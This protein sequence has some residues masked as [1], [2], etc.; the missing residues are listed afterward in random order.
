MYHKKPIPEPISAPQ[1]TMSS[2]AIW[3]WGINKYSAINWLPIAYAIKPKPPPIKIVGK[4]ARPSRPSVR[5]TAFEE[6]TITKDPNKINESM[7]ISKIQSLLKRRI[8]DISALSSAVK[9]KKLTA[10][11]ETKV[12]HKSFI[13][14][15]MPFESL[16]FI[17]WKSSKNPISVKPEV[18]KRQTQIYL[19]L[20]SA[21]KRVE[22]N[23]EEIISNPPIVG[24]P[25]FSI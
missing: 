7:L 21:H 24:V 25:D 9:Y 4:I 6:P 13:F 1:N 15:D 20:K 18:M 17:F 8:S 23:N 19:L 22:I 11:T 2:P 5:F 14:P 10:A 12:W 3:R 16:Y